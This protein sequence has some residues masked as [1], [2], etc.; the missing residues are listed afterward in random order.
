LED[1]FSAGH[2]VMTPDTWKSGNDR[3]RARHDFFDARGLAVGRAM[4]VEPCSALAAEPFEPGLSPCWVTS[5]DGYLGLSSDAS[6]RAHAARAVAKAEMELA[7]AL[8]PARVVAAV[9]ALDERD[10]IALGELVDPA[11]WWTVRA[12]ERPALQATA[13]R[14]RQLVRGQAAAVERLRAAVLMVEVRVGE[15]AQPGRFPAEWL[16]AAVEPNEALALGTPGASLLR[17]MLV[18]W[19]VS[20]LDPSRLEGEARLDHGW[21][22]QLLADGD[23]GVLIPP[24]AP[25]TF[26]APAV[27]VSAGFSYRW[28]NYLPGRLNRP[29]AEGNLGLREALHFDNAGHTGGSP[30]VTILDE[31]LRWPIFWELLTSYRLPLDLVEGHSAGRAL[32]LSG[33]R[34]HEVI[35]NPRPAFLG[36]ELEVL[37]VALSRGHGA[38]P[39]YAT[40]PELRIYVGAADA[41]ATQP[42]MPHAWGPMLSLA[43]TGGYATL[44]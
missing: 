21:A 43:L 3:A 30:Y 29:I 35:A 20:Q 36:L 23:A 1:A 12:T 14:A 8:D 5:G 32:L 28:G 10:Q 41:S 7:I 6:D 22:V 44:L 42:S 19:P 38:Y 9:E 11:P 25:V 15:P 37:A 17:P 4:S 39:L 18:E 26:L 27:G 24:H 40:S 33:L 31:E 2:L 13:A 34:A 16:D